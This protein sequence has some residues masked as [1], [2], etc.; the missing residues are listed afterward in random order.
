M[1]PGQRAT[2]RAC[3]C[4]LRAV[5]MLRAASALSP[6]CRPRAV[7]HATCVGRG[8]GV[9]V[10][11]RHPPTAC[12]PRPCCARSVVA[13]YFEHCPGPH[14]YLLLASSS[15]EHGAPAAPGSAQHD[16]MEHGQQGQLQ[17]QEQQGHVGMQELGFASLLGLQLLPAL[18]TAWGATPFLDMLLCRDRAARWV[19]V[20]AL[21]IQLGLVRTPGPG[22]GHVLRMLACMGEGSVCSRPCAL[23]PTP[24]HPIPV[25]RRRRAERRRA[26]AA[27]L[28]VPAG[29]PAGGG[30]RAL[31][32][33]PRVRGAGARR[34]VA[35]QPPF[36][37]RRAAAHTR[38]GRPGGQPWCRGGGGGC[39]GG[40][41][42][43]A[44]GGPGQAAAQA[45]RAGAAAAPA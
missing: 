8:S 44:W 37:A 25:A 30:A 4:P 9:M 6:S 26:R 15:H 27:G 18:R 14:H 33:A 29:G 16:Q 41:G 19:A 28:P 13:R 40:R 20:E 17:E 45:G 24:S 43:R 32:G 34:H 21:A 12:T 36:A 7:H 2:G 3:P 22:V 35:A 5:L 23:H 38:G 42:D 10:I 1:G 31:A 39:R 11:M